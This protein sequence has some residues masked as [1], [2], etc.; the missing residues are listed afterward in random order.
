MDNFVQ[1][2]KMQIRTVIIL[3]FVL[4]ITHFTSTG[5]N[6]PI[7]LYTTLPKIHKSACVED[8]LCSTKEE[9][10]KELSTALKNNKESIRKL[11]TVLY[12]L[13]QIREGDYSVVREPLDKVMYTYNEDLDELKDDII[14]KEIK[15]MARMQECESQQCVGSGDIAND[16]GVI[17]AKKAQAIEKLILNASSWNKDVSEYATSIYSDPT[18]A[19][20]KSQIDLSQVKEARS[21]YENAKEISRIAGKKSKVVSSTKSNQHICVS[22]VI[23]TI[24][25]VEYKL[26]GV[27]CPANEKKCFRLADECIDTPAQIFSDDGG[28]PINEKKIIERN[29][30]TKKDYDKAKKSAQVGLKTED[31]TEVA[32]ENTGSITAGETSS[33]SDPDNSGGATAAGATDTGSVK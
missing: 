19:Y 8:S 31:L 12:T 4:I 20:S 21:Q 25:G 13:P 27:H 1:G 6:S 28:V 24:S 2:R 16:I 18:E 22:D 7:C 9:T 29:K 23:C 3:Y 17:R 14:P 5:S 32:G 10:D 11:N 15:L 30:T 26:K 33:T